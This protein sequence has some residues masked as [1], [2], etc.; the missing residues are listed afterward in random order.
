MSEAPLHNLV[1]PGR[2]WLGLVVVPS[3]LGFSQLV[4]VV[5]AVVG[6]GLVDALQTL[7]GLVGLVVVVGYERTPG[8][9]GGGGARAG[10][11]GSATA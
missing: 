1:G 7:L 4:V 11:G 10:A 2:L 3:R 9:V 6:V 5:E 8:V